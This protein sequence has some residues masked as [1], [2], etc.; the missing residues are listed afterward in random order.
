MG[1]SG[2]VCW[3]LPFSSFRGAPQ[4]G[5]FGCWHL[6]KF[7]SDFADGAAQKS[8]FFFSPHL[9]H[10]CPG[11]MQEFPIWECPA[12]LGEQLH[13]LL[14]KPL[15]IFCSPEFIPAKLPGA[16][17]GRAAFPCSFPGPAAR[18][19]PVHPLSTLTH[20]S[21]LSPGHPRST[22]ARSNNSSFI[23]QE[24]P[25]RRGWAQGEAG[26]VP[27]PTALPRSL[28]ESPVSSKMELR[29]VAGAALGGE[30]PCPV[31]L[32]ELSRG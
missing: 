25:S 4:L 21:C 15:L 13:P 10:L 8:L 7:I 22:R 9:S 5:K 32:D 31:P 12:L 11:R 26:I 18:R 27:I 19:V 20:H 6:P 28:K 24:L 16:G 3:N 29:G 17:S 14:P 2:W 1:P 30:G 23:P